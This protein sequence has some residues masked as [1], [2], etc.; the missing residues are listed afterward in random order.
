MGTDKLLESTDFIH[1]EHKDWLNQLNFYQDEIKFF[2]N[3]LVLVLHANH[4]SFSFFE[5]IDE[6][7]K[8]FLKKLKK[9]DSMRHQVII[10]EKKLSG[11]LETE[12]QD[13]KEHREIRERFTKFVNDFELLKKNFNR[14]AAHN[15]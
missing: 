7:K 14:F 4:T 8:I 2:Q 12:D 1:R 11:E 5:T 9:I 10:H 13:L 15:D 6:Y 3:E